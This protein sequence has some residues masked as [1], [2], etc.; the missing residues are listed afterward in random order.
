MSSEIIVITGCIH[1]QRSRKIAD[2]RIAET[3]SVTCPTGSAHKGVGTNMRWPIPRLA[4]KALSGQWR[5][6]T[7]KSGERE[8]RVENLHTAAAPKTS[9]G[10]VK[11]RKRR[12]TT[13]G[14]RA[15]SLDKASCGAGS[16]AGLGCFSQGRRQGSAAAADHA[17]TRGVAGAHREGGRA[18]PRQGS[19]HTQKTVTPGAAPRWVAP[20]RCRP[21]RTSPPVPAAPHALRLRAILWRALLRCRPVPQAMQCS[22]WPVRLR[23]LHQVRA[24]LPPDLWA[25]A[26][27]HDNDQR[28]NSVFR[29]PKEPA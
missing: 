19:A 15:P 13:S 17:R 7:T 23:I 16:M 26:Q 27:T 12:A 1:E 9:C 20:P 8:G 25:G 24:G 22:P 11:W 10:S 14:W 21:A 18:A 2:H 5:P 28:N 3:K 4:P 6:R 29:F